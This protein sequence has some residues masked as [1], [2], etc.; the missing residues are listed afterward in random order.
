MAQEY[1]ACCS[2]RPYLSPSLPSTLSLS[3]FRRCCIQF[4][5]FDRSLCSRFWTFFSFSTMS[6]SNFSLWFETAN[7]GCAQHCI[8]IG[9]N[10][11]HRS[12]LLS[13]YL[14]SLE[15]L[16][17]WCHLF[18]LPQYAFDCRSLSGAS[19]ILGPV[20]SGTLCAVCVFEDR[21]ANL[22]LFSK[23]NM[24]DSKGNFM[25]RDQHDAAHYVFYA[26][27]I[28]QTTH[29]CCLDHGIEFH[30]LAS[31]NWFVDVLVL[32]RKKAEFSKLFFASNIN[33]RFFYPLKV[34]ECDSEILFVGEKEQNYYFCCPIVQYSAKPSP[35]SH[36]QSVCGRK[37]KC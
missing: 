25:A 6:N 3:L 26:F 34:F 1:H 12:M 32:A 11:K 17:E 5:I 35:C 20:E 33:C 10:A 24:I 31:D 4:F 36:S 15:M 14:N 28:V 22:L 27:A 37:K 18:S 21:I 19:S 9:P 30:C 8:V 16:Y 23:L 29:T 13:I 7:D 2:P